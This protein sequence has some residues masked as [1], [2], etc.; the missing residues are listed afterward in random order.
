PTEIDFEKK[1]EIE[2]IRVGNESISGKIFYTKKAIE[3]EEDRGI[4]II[5]HGRYITTENFGVIGTK[6]DR[7]T[8]YVHAD[9]LIDEL[10]GDKTQVRKN[11]N[12]WRKLSQEISKQLS[13]F[14]KEIGETEE[15]ELPKELMKKV[16][17][18]LNKLL[19]QIPEFQK[20]ATTK[21]PSEVLIQKEQGEVPVSMSRGSQR[22][23]GTEKGPGSG[24]G[25]SVTPG[26]EEREAPSGEIGSQRATRQKRK[27]KKGIEMKIVSVPN[28]KREAWFSPGESVVYINAS[29]PT[30]NKAV[31]EKASA[32]HILRC[33]IEALL[34]YVCENE[35]IDNVKKFEE[36][37]NEI[38]S[39]WGEL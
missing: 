34:R 22:V 29:F 27:I 1:K 10:A 28:E 6:S 38:L 21:K 33:A 5:V 15:K 37:R 8:G 25:V 26:T 20:V 14:L 30:Y 3:N 18:E 9:A 17:E 24:A 32:Y 4:K 19:R 35:E 12:K 36:K 13:D 16:H 23:P 7:I 31:K 11:S 2:D 39:L